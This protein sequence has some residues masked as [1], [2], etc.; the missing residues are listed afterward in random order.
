[1]IITAGLVTLVSALAI[2]QYR[3]LGEVSDAERAR[4]QAS[5]K[6]RADDFARDIDR[7]VTNLYDTFQ[8]AGVM[9]RRGD[10][11]GFAERA[12][13]W[14]L[15][16]PVAGLV[17][18]VYRITAH[19]DLERYADRTFTKIE[20]PAELKALPRHPVSGPIVASV[21]A[22]VIPLPSVRPFDV[23]ESAGAR[24]RGDVFSFQ[25]D[26]ESLVV[27]LDREY[28]TKTFLPSMAERS[29]PSAANDFT[30]AIVDNTDASNA[31]FSRGLA[32]GGAIDPTHADVN[33]DVFAIRPE[34][35]DPVALSA[36]IVVGS[37]GSRRGASLGTPMVAMKD[38]RAQI[39]VE[40][41]STL[42]TTKSA[43]FTTVRSAAGEPGM[44]LLA[45]HVSGSLETVVGQARRRNLMLSFGML[46]LLGVSAGLLVVNARRSQRL[47]AQQ[48]DFVAAISHELR[49][50]IAVI[51]SAGQNLSAGLVG[52][53]AQT[54]RYGEL[55]DKEG[56]R[57]TDM[58]E[59]VLEFAG[60]DSQHR[61]VPARPIDLVQLA[62]EVVSDP[63]LSEGSTAVIEI[64]ASDTVPPVRGD[65]AG[66]VRVLR[67]LVANALKHGGRSGPIGIS[68]GRHT[69]GPADAVRLSVT[70]AGPG[71]D[72][73]DLPHIFEP[74]YRGRRAV[75]QQIRGNGLGLSLVKRTVE[76][77]GGSI[78]VESEPGRGATFT[79][80]LPAASS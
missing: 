71:I 35:A 31:I 34:L 2:F 14:A 79:V 4:L 7:A 9:L 39:F 46:A 73:E 67:N 65:E 33:V 63:A 18:G 29:F 48:M 42:S 28:L 64:H 41:R 19:G 75:D 62:R 1:M 68:I 53:A 24:G 60:F 49:T 45:Q 25:F 78:R 17:K 74:F 77:H 13:A 58:V 54:R 38:A 22:L 23:L 66:L 10:L 36:R 21:P 26:M 59:E 50:P 30:L 55:I 37:L 52:D 61:P 72:A 80:E 5:L 8:H 6:Q 12:D 20:W 11:T 57:L 44:R 15:S 47:A 51:R 43:T 16:S 27:W 40:Q 3:W 32:T 56:R 69:T 70:D 76:S